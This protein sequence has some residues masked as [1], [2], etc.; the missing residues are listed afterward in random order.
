MI[1]GLLMQ[2]GP[3]E[4]PPLLLKLQAQLGPKEGILLW[5]K[6]TSSQILRESPARTLSPSR[7]ALKPSYSQV[8]KTR[9][10]AH[11][12]EKL[13]CAPPRDTS[14]GPS[15]CVQSRVF[16]ARKPEENFN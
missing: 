12:P 4:L 6:P 8:V 7:P 3:H 2:Y 11:D 10:V 1:R 13:S 16:S 9:K 5:A 14:C 15:H